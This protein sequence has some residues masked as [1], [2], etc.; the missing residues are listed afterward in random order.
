[1]KKLWL[2]GLSLCSILLAGC[3]NGDEGLVDVPNGGI[4]QAV[5]IVVTPKNAQIPV[6]LPLQF[7]AVAT[8][9]DGTTVDVTSNPSLSWSSSNNDIATIDSQG[10]L[11]SVSTGQVT[12]TAKGINKD[13]SIVED[14]SDVTVTNAAVSELLVTPKT[15]SV[16][17]G[18][19]QAFKAEA[20]MS[21]GQV[22]DV[23]KNSELTWSSSDT[24]VASINDDG[25]NKGQALGLAAGTT[26]IKAQ[27]MVGDTEFS[28]TAVL[29]VNEATIQSFN[30]SPDATSIPVGLDTALKAEVT[31]T[32]G[33]VKD[34]TQDADWTTT[35]PTVLDVNNTE[36]NKGSI[37]AKKTSTS[38]VDVTA[39]ITIAGTEYTDSTA[40]TVTTATVTALSVTPETAALPI[41]LTQEFIAQAELSDGTSLDVTKNTAVSWTTSD[42][43][44][45][46]V[47]KGIVTSV[48]EGNVTIT[49]VG[50]VGEQRFSDSATLNVTPT[51]VTNII[52]SPQSAN[53]P[54]G[55]TK[56]FTATAVFSDDSELDVTN[57]AAISWT[58]GEATIATVSNDVD[59]KGI[60]KGESVGK[61]T[62]T[63]TGVLGSQSLQATAD[64][65]VT[66]AVITDF[67]VTP[68]IS[69]SALGLPTSFVATA[70]LSDS[71]SLDVTNN[72]EVSW[73]SSDTGVAT[74]TNGDI[75]GNGVATGIAV[76]V[77]NITAS[78][79]V[80]GE[81]WQSSGELTINNAAIVGI[82]IDTTDNEV[83][84]GK[85]LAMKA[86]GE[87]SDG[88]TTDLTADDR[89]TWVIEDTS[90]A[91]VSNAAEDK[92]TVTGIKLG[93]TNI[94]VSGEFDGLT[95][96]ATTALDVVGPY[97]RPLL[98]DETTY[99]EDTKEE[100]VYVDSTGTTQMPGP[101]PDIYGYA[102]VDID[103]A[104][105]E[106]QLRG[107]ELAS[108][109]TSLAAYLNEGNDETST[110]P[111]NFRYFWTT[112]M[113]TGEVESWFEYRDSVFFNDDTAKFEISGQDPN[114]HAFVICEHK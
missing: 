6:G 46:T 58:T 77:T 63:A 86:I 42:S 70:T 102:A 28:D 19:S 71:T 50:V 53:T 72:P 89:S 95:L 57:D 99:E 82:S 9:D 103:V 93:S 61:T 22:I 44:I 29:T 31:L 16:A 62:I 68:A 27:G 91:S 90:L 52:I 84:V 111:L 112:K 78:A 76:G 21:D 37:H 30:V 107:E 45:A 83:A 67:Q 4:H 114:S 73:S 106:C 13:G 104:I 35:D 81:N 25:T 101:G 7:E 108:N 74:V 32:D 39:S 26:E 87:L 1:M 105:A 48:A 56:Q 14:T 69:A 38:P 8:L 36:G 96:D 33:S 79:T 18:L 98:A 66:K 80:N 97:R 20:I 23:T 5:S 113:S 54:V 17:K 49:A 2:F 10:L 100:I 94:T 43:S 47:D 41:G 24:A 85:T 59:G 51:V 34:V 12:I 60:V 109:P 88:N 55:L 110:W 65:E 92:G 64:L 3:N 15:A 75:D 11:A 40:I